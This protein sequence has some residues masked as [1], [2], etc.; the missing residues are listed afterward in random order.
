MTQTKP[1][2]FHSLTF[3]DAGRAR[4]FL[5]ALGFTEVLVV[6]SADDPSVIE[7][8][9]LRWRETGGVMFGSVREA[10]PFAGPERVG[11]ASCYLV[12][13][14]DHEV[15]EVFRRGLAAGGSVVEEPADQPYG[16]RS[17]TVADP[18]GNHWSVGSYQGE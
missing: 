18:E 8:A 9:Q 2:L 5:T 3:A 6:P 15:D 12:V 13:A 17:A 1:Q 11:R 16:G 7:H 14:E 10:N 4:T